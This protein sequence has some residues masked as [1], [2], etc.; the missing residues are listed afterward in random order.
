MT[1]K[2]E[3]S[4]VQAF[5]KMWKD[6]TKTGD[7]LNASQMDAAQKMMKHATDMLS[8][9]KTQ[10]ASITMG[11]KKLKFDEKELVVR[12]KLK[13]ADEHLV[14]LRHA[15]NIEQEREHGDQVR[16]NINLRN[17]MD[18][19]ND[20]FNML[21]KSLTGGFGFQAAMDKSVKN[22]GSMT[23]VFQ[24]QKHAG[25]AFKKA[26]KEAAEALRKLQIAFLTGDKADI[27]E[28]TTEYE[29]K[30]ER[31]A[32]TKDT[33]EHTTKDAKKAGVMGKFKGVFE[34]FDK[35][36]E[37]LGKKAVPIGI[38]M[39]V[40]GVLMSVIV[41]AFS[42]SPLFAQMMK[43]MKFMVTLIL[44]PI[45]TFFG[46]LL[47]PILILLL[48]KFIVPFYSTWMPVL[49]K[50]GGQ[51]GKWL[52]AWGFGGEKEKRTDAWGDEYDANFDT[53]P[54]Y[55]MT[56][57]E[58]LEAISN[59]GKGDPSAAQNPYNQFWDRQKWQQWEDMKSQAMTQHT[60][61]YTGENGSESDEENKLDD[62]KEETERTNSLLTVTNSII[63]SGNTST[64]GDEDGVIQSNADFI[65]QTAAEHGLGEAEFIGDNIQP[66]EHAWGRGDELP[67]YVNPVTA[68]EEAG[69][70]SD[71]HDQLYKDAINQHTLGDQ[72]DIF[73]ESRNVGG[74]I[75]DV[76]PKVMTQEM[77]NFAAYGNLNPDGTPKT[78]KGGDI[79]DAGISM[80]QAEIDKLNAGYQG[81]GGLSSTVLEGSGG[82][83]SQSVMDNYNA[84]LA[85]VVPAADGFNGMVN[86]PTMF[87][88]GESGSEHVSITP[89]GGSG[90]ITVNIQNMNG[91]DNDLRKLKQTILEVIQQSSANRGRL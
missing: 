64:P 55:L 81:Y 24:E 40:A 83:S 7:K 8:N 76:V 2:E 80:T 26:T 47:R 14:K 39:G 43:M 46:A 17:N 62:I 19:F 90:G 31:E 63:G 10:K 45:G 11:N 32:K 53:N 57:E 12:E 59:A 66:N 9:T 25:N 71:F 37:F 67:E 21:K 61:T 78:E 28:A 91:S 86:S 27:Q 38:G 51:V 4:V 73:Q 15:L 69:E 44:M 52:T 68:P 70:L 5:I 75:A 54:W 89:N 49:M 87:L 13:K 48:R 18:S 34:R 16:R 1:L 29:A 41:K 6:L 58:F 72:E 33:F 30:K 22:M 82:R 84:Y 56:T 60:A 85:G 35:I 36:S 3:E 74:I 42:A 79:H 88:A 20:K 77:T 23:R 65:A 50:V